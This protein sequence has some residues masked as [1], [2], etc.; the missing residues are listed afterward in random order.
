[1]DHVRKAAPGSRKP[2]HFGAAA[3]LPQDRKSTGME[4]NAPGPCRRMPA[5]VARRLNP[6]PA[7]PT[8]G[9]TGIR[10]LAKAG[11][12]ERSPTAFPRKPRPS[13]GRAGKLHGP[14]LQGPTDRFNAF[15]R[16]LRAGRA[17][18]PH[19]CLVRYRASPAGG[20][21]AGC[22]DGNRDPRERK[23]AA[24]R[25]RGAPAPMPDRHPFKG[26][27]QPEARRET[28]LGWGT[29]FSAS[30][31]HA[32]FGMFAIFESPAASCR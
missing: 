17:E 23:G 8:V 12:A 7:G 32:D 30:R 9:R 1:M 16:P 28:G 27:G 15:F 21:H 14:R 10:V 31:L 26:P 13:T 11:T 18:P 5:S 24:I 29:R 22:R 19:P 20:R 25:G 2:G 6:M 4:A 3:G